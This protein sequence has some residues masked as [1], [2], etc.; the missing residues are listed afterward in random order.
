VLT[1]WDRRHRLDEQTRASFVRTDAA[2]EE[3][4][5]IQAVGVG[6]T[7]NRPA[8]LIAVIV[9]VDSQ[10]VR[11]WKCNSPSRGQIERT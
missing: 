2:P 8:D 1:D 9:F 3:L 6:P 11:Y 10:R 7:A 5:G 4:A